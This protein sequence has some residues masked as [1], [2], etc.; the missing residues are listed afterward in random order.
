MPDPQFPGQTTLG[1]SK[2]PR[3][4]DKPFLVYAKYAVSKSN[5]IFSAGNPVSGRFIFFW[6][7]SKL[8]K[9]LIG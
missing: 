2:I 1:W 9:I 8:N 3:I 6:F 4:W 7:E 5:P